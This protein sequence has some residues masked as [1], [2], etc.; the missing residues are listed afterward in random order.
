MLR[1]L[2]ILLLIVQPALAAQ[3]T[4]PTRPSGIG[5]A[6]PSDSGQN[7]PL[8]LTLIR[9]GPQPLAIINGATLKL[10]G[11]IG[12]YQLLALRPGRAVL[13]SEAGQ[14][15]LPLVASLHQNST[16]QTSGTR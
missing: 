16:S 14:L 13:A 4:D 10:G 1:N 5:V 8:R 9:L 7:A 15:T 11:R 12:G 6:A 2:L 3:L